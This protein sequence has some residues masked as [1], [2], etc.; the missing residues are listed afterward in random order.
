MGTNALI[1]FP[2]DALNFPLRHAFWEKNVN[3]HLPPQMHI[4]WTVA[5]PEAIR[6]RHEGNWAAEELDGIDLLDVCSP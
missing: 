4:E 2:A 3:H 5:F 6:L 1:I